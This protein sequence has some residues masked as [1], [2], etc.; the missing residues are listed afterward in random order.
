MNNFV[1]MPALFDSDKQ[2][3]SQI[4][5]NLLKV[6]DQDPKKSKA[7]K[8]FQSYGV[9]ESLDFE[10]AKSAFLAGELSNQSWINQ[11]PT[12]AARLASEDYVAIARDELGNLIETEGTWNQLYNGWKIARDTVAIGN[13]GT[14]AMME[15]RELYPYERRKIE[16]SRELQR[17]HTQSM[18]GWTAAASELTG[19][20]L[21]TAGY[22][23]AAGV[24][25]S[26]LFPPAAPFVIGG[27]AFATSFNL[28]AGNL[29]ADL[30]MDGYTAS[31][32]AGIAAGY[33]ALIAAVDTVGLKY[34]TAGAKGLGKELLPNLFK[35]VRSAALRK[36]TLTEA[37][38]DL[39]KDL[40]GV[41]IVEPG[42]E[43]TQEVFSEFAKAEASRLYRPEDLYEPEYAEVFGHAYWHTFKGMAILGGI[44]SGVRYI[45]NA[46]RSAEAQ[47]ADTQIQEGLEQQRKSANPEVR[48]ELNEA[49]GETTLHSTYYIDAEGF[50]ETVDQIA[51][52]DPNFR[53]QLES[54]LRGFLG[55]ISEAAERGGRVQV[56]KAKF[57]KVF[58]LTSAQEVVSQ[59][60]AVEEDGMT[61]L[62]SDYF[63]KNK[64]RLSKEIRKE[65]DEERVTKEKFQEEIEQV[66]K[67]FKEALAP[68]IGVQADAGMTANANADILVGI[69]RRNALVMGISPKVYAEKYLP[70]IIQQNLDA[71]Q[72]AQTQQQQVRNQP[73][74]YPVGQLLEADPNKFYRGFQAIHELDG[75]RHMMKGEFY[76]EAFV[77]EIDGDIESYDVGGDGVSNKPGV[78][79]GRIPSDKVSR[80]FVD[81]NAFD[82]YDIETVNELREMFPNAEV[83]NVQL[84]EEVDAV[85]TDDG[86]VVADNSTL[87][88]TPQQ[89]AEAETGTPLNSLQVDADETPEQQKAR[90][91]AS[92]DAKEAGGE[93]IPAP[94]RVMTT[95]D[96]TTAEQAD[97]LLARLEK[98]LVG[99]VSEP[100]GTVTEG[101]E[102]REGG[103]TVVPLLA[104]ARLQRPIKEDIAAV[105]ARRAQLVA[106]Q[107]TEDR[108]NTLD[109]LNFEQ[110]ADYTFVEA[111]YRPEVV[112]W[113]REQFGDRMA[114][115]GKPVYQNFTR[116]FGDSA[117]TT[118]KEF[119]SEDKLVI[120]PNGIPIPVYHGTPTSGF[121][122]FDPA[123]KGKGK[124][125][126]KDTGEESGFFFTSDPAAA[127]RFTGDSEDRSGIYPVYLSMQNPLIVDDFAV[128]TDVFDQRFM[129]DLIKE[130]KEGG[131]DGV[132]GKIDEAVDEDLLLDRTPGRTTRSF[133]DKKIETVTTPK[134]GKTK[135][136]TIT[137]PGFETVASD[138]GITN[139]AEDTGTVRPLYIV[140]DSNQI[141]S[142]QN[143]GN[144][145]A[146]ENIL[147]SSEGDQKKTLGKAVFTDDVIKKILLDPDAKPTTLMHELMHWNLEMMASMGLEIESKASQEGYEATIE[148]AVML[149]DI[150]ALL[151]WSG[152]EGTLTQWESMTVD[153]RRQFHE[154]IA[155]S[156]EKYL[157]EGVA[158][159]PELKG[160]FSRLL[161]Y[162]R[163]MYE[164]VI[165]RINAD[166]KRE[167]KRDLPS[168]DNGDIR[169]V[170]GRMM[171]SEREV[172]NYR[173]VYEAEAMTME[174]WVESRGGKDLNDE[175]KA[176]AEA[177]WREYNQEFLDSINEAKGDLTQKRMEEVGFQQRARQRVNAEISKERKAAQK[178]LKEEVQN[179]LQVQPVFQLQGII[180]NKEGKYHTE[181]GLVKSPKTGATR[182]LNRAE[183]ERLIKDPVK[184]KNID[185]LLAADGVPF[186][187]YVDFFSFESI[188]DLA[189]QLADS[190]KLNRA[191]ELEVD[192]RML[193]EYSDLTD[194]I[195]IE[196]R[197][198]AAVHNKTRRRVIALEL[199]A[200]LKNG[201]KEAEQVRLMRAL[202]QEIIGKE[203]N[204]KINLSEYSRAAAQARKKSLKA[205]KDG[206]MEAAAFAKRQELLN[207]SLV[208]E[209]LRVREEARKMVRLNKTIFRQ[210]SDQKLG[211]TREIEIVK[212][213][214][215]LLSMFG[216][217]KATQEISK[218]LS[219]FAARNPEY[220]REVQVRLNSLMG[221][222][223]SLKGP[224]TGDR[225]TKLERM[226]VED[227]Q[228]LYFLA[229]EM[230]KYSAYVRKVEIDGQKVTVEEA[231]AAAMA[232]LARIK[233]Q[234]DGGFWSFLQNTGSSLRRVEHLFRRIDGG[235]D[236]PWTK[237]FR[238]IKDAANNYRSELLLFM[239][240]D[241]RT[242]KGF[243]YEG[244][245]KALDLKMPNGMKTV[246]ATFGGEAVVFGSQSLSAK[247]EIIHLAM[248]FYGNP[249]NK[250]KVVSGYADVEGK[251]AKEVEASIEKFLKDMID[252]GALTKADFAFMQSVFDQLNSNNMLGRAQAVMRRLRGSGFESIKS[253]SFIVTFPD[254]TSKEYGGGYIPVHFEK[255]ELAGDAVTDYASQSVDMMTATMAGYLPVTTPAKFATERTKTPYKVQLGLGQVSRHAAEVYRYINMAEAS[256]NVSKVIESKEIK[257]A[258]NSRFG[259]NT[260]KYLKAWL[261]R[262]TLQRAQEPTTNEFYKFIQ[263]IS[264]SANMGI[265][266][267]NVG[268]SIQNYAGLVLPMREVGTRGVVSALVKY[269]A[270]GTAGRN[271]IIKDIVSKSS[272]MKGRLEKQIFDIYTEQSNM[273]ADTTSKTAK[274]LNYARSKAYFLQQITQNHVDIAVWQ[275]AYNKETSKALSENMSEADAE[276]RAVAYAD[277]IV[278]RTQMAGNPED[279]SMFEA[280]DSLAKAMF[281]FKSWFINWLNNASTQGRLDLDSD[282]RAK[283]AELFSSYVYLLMIPAVLAQAATELARGELLND[284]DDDDGISDDLTEMFFMSQISQAV[285]GIPVLSDGLRMMTNLMDDRYWNNRYPTL[286]YK[287]ALENIYKAPFKLFEDPSFGAAFDFAGAVATVTGIPLEA[288]TDRASIIVDQMTGELRSESTYDAIR[289]QITGKRSASQRL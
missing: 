119:D 27:T 20:M 187:S 68:V 132:I 129:M 77:I 115:N 207:E 146:D 214:R 175:E 18:P 134:T 272:E 100:M 7:L 188:E 151:K 273:L 279:I 94:S 276:K 224:E 52:T 262:S 231:K 143:Q 14:R 78:Y 57:E 226:K 41:A 149:S 127:D 219:D 117:V 202:A 125:S 109:A 206:D 153:Q 267:M 38:K 70:M 37:A 159:S 72:A 79:R 140:F 29:Y 255:Q 87:R 152:F 102:N 69:V 233:E 265:M 227:L 271:N 194:P 181:D 1:G 163:S 26:A 150:K 89:Q 215:A 174:E 35:N 76:P 106:E 128:S 223:A 166:Y 113:A 160:I 16:R 53:Q 281:P 34:A 99:V 83:V 107:Q 56:S 84:A 17:A 112:G 288:I 62:E 205:L 177:E 75:L 137:G 201:V 3:P 170:F 266:F 254:G 154:A 23:A 48:E 50:K 212:A 208:I 162:A 209:G 46:A 39:G 126:G 2:L 269:A 67:S 81:V 90:M 178:R 97:E 172:E 191:V 260:G 114:P 244:K 258:L 13:M 80:I 133:P 173:Q 243:D 124:F 148:E 238:T 179:E 274:G 198:R 33:G 287:R 218:A 147:E 189:Q 71:K 118:I 221:L 22:S 63:E 277:S 278:R 59:H 10:Q 192:R 268:N 30:I 42:T 12:L 169:A 111:D 103:Q 245:I 264:R 286:P 11:Y 6:P 230:W 236:G 8:A 182:K 196:E 136:I 141:K 176:A 289:A 91:E 200:L 138:I 240:K 123:R 24:A 21:E 282:G 120:D 241:K 43:G 211:K 184:L 168:L 190:R 73:Q 222:A 284:D 105:K 249:S 25:A 15:G 197:V 261:N 88:V 45:R 167:F 220:Y 250:E 235:K 95:T 55:K 164:S 101:G 60:V 144:F 180:N 275:A 54:E 270:N 253:S 237:M 248:H 51:K 193:E 165:E 229:R 108:S 40:A 9:D 65:S 31:E 203:E 98:S 85:K 19:T 228:S 251:N 285:G 96:I 5:N 246:S 110:D 36:K 252:S 217:G 171:S 142:T 104:R 157:Y 47:V 86:L 204:G 4:R 130:A 210:K 155:V 183:A 242:G 156:F 66:R 185:H 161:A 121:G 28:E 93:S 122:V 131:Y 139:A 58:A 92:L 199:R 232:P 49:A 195:L 216:V 213:L 263:F 61:K 259:E 74:N 64:E 158:P 82:G 225:L 145:S 32:A 44:P 257:Q 239:S 256:S 116:W 247:S 234:K 280:G 186:E 135:Q 283:A